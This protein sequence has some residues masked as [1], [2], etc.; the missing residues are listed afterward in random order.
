MFSSADDPTRTSQE[1]M[2]KDNL[3][4]RM[5]ILHMTKHSLLKMQMA[6]PTY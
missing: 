5:Y 4:P 3:S 1:T 2:D 6:Q